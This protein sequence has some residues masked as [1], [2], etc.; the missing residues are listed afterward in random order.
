MVENVAASVHNY[1]R[2]GESFRI[3]HGSTNS[4]RQIAYQRGNVVD[5]SPLS[6][7]LKVDVEARTALVEPNVP[8]D[9][10]VESTLKHGLVPPVVMEFPGITAGGGFS[11]TGGES[12][13]FKYGYFNENVNSVEMVLGNGDVFTASEKERPDLFQGASGAVGSLG[14]T[15]LLELQLTQAREYVKVTYQPVRSISEAIDKLQTEISTPE[16]EYVDGILFSKTHGAVVT[17][18]LTDDLPVAAVIQTFSA[19]KDPWY[20]LHVKEKTLQS[21]EP[22]TEYIPLA[23]Y[24]FRYDRGGFWVGASAFD[25]FKFPFN[26]ITRWLLDDSMHTRMLYKALHASRHSRNFVIQDL[27]L[28]FSTAEAFLDYAIESF[29]IWPLWLCP[30]RRPN[31]PTFHPHSHG[32]EAE[33]KAPNVLLNIGLWGSGPTQHDKFIA[34]NRELEQKLR[35]LGGTKWLYAHAYYEEGEFWEIYDRQ[36]YEGLRRKYNAELLPS[37]WHKVNVDQDTRKHGADDSW[38]VRVLQFW[39]L[40][41]VWGLLK[42]IKSGEW[43]VA[44][45][46][47][48]KASSS[49]KKK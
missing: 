18:C 42:A 22:V 15:T 37:V 16:I 40:G 41:G 7:V 4:T 35:D 10:L 1:F 25:Y 26:R 11:G 6:R 32:A 17:G 13:S 21:T 33:S 27:A 24:L 28:P 49:P 44:R 46:S 19:A 12:S 34:K 45:R 29:D 39:P 23:E 48:W 9:R 36:W 43:L 2:R 38:R 3:F 5:I 30:L 20:Y 47:T 8:M 14:I 31:L